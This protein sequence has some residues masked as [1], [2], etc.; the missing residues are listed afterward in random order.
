ML[1]G[2]GAE[3]VV[4]LELISVLLWGFLYLSSG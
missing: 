4:S 3:R 2:A 1:G